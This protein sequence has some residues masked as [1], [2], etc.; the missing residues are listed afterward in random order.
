M[1][2]ELQIEVVPV[3]TSSDAAMAEIVALCNRAYGEDVAGYFDLLP[4]STS[5]I[6][7]KAGVIVSHAMWVTRWLELDMRPPY[8]RTAYV[9]MV[10]TDPAHQR[11]GYAAAVMRRLAASIVDYDLGALCP[12]DAGALL[13][14]ALGW[15]IWRGPLFIR[16]SHELIPTPAERVMVLRLP[17]TPPLDLSAPLS[18]EW[19]QGDLW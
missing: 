2:A 12:S 10:A 18:A 8:L 14:P 6:A 11:Q 5:V 7:R 13:Y 1:N 9:E 19:R 15:E 3:A 17:R 16:G 4:N